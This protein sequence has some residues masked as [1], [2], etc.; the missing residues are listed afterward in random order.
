[1]PPMRLDHLARV[2]AANSQSNTCT[3]EHPWDGL[4]ARLGWR[5]SCLL[6]RVFLSCPAWKPALRDSQ[7]GYP[8]FDIERAASALR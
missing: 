3:D 7:D 6:M 8:P 2:G 4:Q 5:A 1:M